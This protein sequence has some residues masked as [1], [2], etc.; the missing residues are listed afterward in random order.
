M[1]KMNLPRH[2]ISD[3]DRYVA[4]IRRE[5][6]GNKKAYQ[7]MSNLDRAL[8]G[9]N[10]ALHTLDAISAQREF[11]GT[12][13]EEWNPL[14]QCPT[15]NTIDFNTHSLTSD[16]QAIAQN[17]TNF[18]QLVHEGLHVILLDDFFSSENSKWDKPRSFVDLYLKSEAFAF[19][20]TDIV[21]TPKL[22]ARL[23]DT[24]LVFARSTVSSYYF[25]P[26]RALEAIG[27][28]KTHDSLALYLSAFSGF[29][30]KLDRSKKRLNVG[31]RQRI[32]SFYVNSQTPL[33]QLHQSLSRAGIF[34]EYAKVFCRIEGLPRL[35]ADR[36]QTG[37]EDDFFHW[38]FQT[39]L[40][41]ISKMSEEHLIAVRLR[42]RIQTRA[43]HAWML[44]HVLSNVGVV[45]STGAKVEIPEDVDHT[46]QE[47]L[48]G[49]KVLIESLCELN[50]VGPADM[51]R[52]LKAL[53]QTIED[54]DA[55]FESG[56]RAHTKVSQ[57]WVQR[58]DILLKKNSPNLSVR[59][60]GPLPNSAKVPQK[61]IDV[62]FSII[63]KEI[64]RSAKTDFQFSKI[65][66]LFSQ[67]SSAK[68]PWKTRLFNALIFH[69]SVLPLW[70]VRLSDIDPKKSEFREL[71][72]QYE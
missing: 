49:M 15:V 34:D 29:Q 67:M 2:L 33:T 42:R 19:W 61:Y 27:L 64:D 48:T 65:L 14:T 24:E 36:H 72:F 51:R 7:K 11:F 46:L 40:P 8:P 60:F 26:Y 58:R 37:A 59:S 54:F 4:V 56:F 13:I 22:R 55:S 45:D 52:G 39:G 69:R 25:H 9:L 28:K 50:K 6:Q 18:L 32:Q 38:M 3:C 1:D 10:K 71:V 5:I 31:L 68:G 12:V 47:Y 62:L 43:Y 41:R 30:T 44:H 20:Y 23:P 21:V 16:F 66:I 57:L 35:F 17:V 63:S 53:S 70:S